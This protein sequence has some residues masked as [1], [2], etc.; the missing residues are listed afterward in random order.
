MALV[1][2]ERWLQFV[3]VFYDSAS[4]LLGTPSSSSSRSEQCGVL[5]HP[6]RRRP[7][8]GPCGLPRPERWHRPAAHRARPRAGALGRRRAVDTGTIRRRDHEV[9][10]R[11]YR[12]TLSWDDEAH[13]WYVSGTTFPA[14]S[15]RPAPCR[16]YSRSCAAS[17]R[18][19][20][21]STITFSRTEPCAD[22]PAAPGRYSQSWTIWDQ[23]SSSRRPGSLSVPSACR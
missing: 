3:L 6:R 8:C 13:V 23:A 22:P 12:A 10:G 21:S 9:T 11:T 4:S 7:C 1:D 20:S 19:S 18:N 5:R 16:R 2:S 17:F 15:P 14:W